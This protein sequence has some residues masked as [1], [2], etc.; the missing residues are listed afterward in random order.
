MF[1]FRKEFKVTKYE[2]FLL[3]EREL[4]EPNRRD[5]IWLTS[6]DHNTGCVMVYF[7]PALAMSI[8]ELM[9][10]G[11]SFCLKS[12]LCLKSLS[13]KNRVSA[14]DCIHVVRPAVSPG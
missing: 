14:V 3:L 9:A 5:F 1:S 6:F 2:V 13:A 7:S 11:L 12:G 10:L 8:I 4:L